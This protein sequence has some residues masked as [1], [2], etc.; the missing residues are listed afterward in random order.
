MSF[1]RITHFRF[2]WEFNQIFALTAYLTLF[3]YVVYCTS[4]GKL[5]ASRDAWVLIGMLISFFFRRS[6]PS[7]SQPIPTEK[8]SVETFGNT[9]NE[10][11][12]P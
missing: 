10:D 3:G 11:L 12:K 7:T 6:E 5:D 8:V 2:K 9:K 4:T 1:P